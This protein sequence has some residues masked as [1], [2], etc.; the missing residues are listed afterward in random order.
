MEALAILP[1]PKTPE[2]LNAEP[3]KD[4]FNRIK[5][6][7]DELD[8]NEGNILIVTHG[9]ALRMAMY[10]AENNKEF[11][12]GKYEK[13]KLFKMNNGDIFEWDQ[14]SGIKKF[15]ENSNQKG[16]I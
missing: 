2:L 16:E 9:G 10:Y 5:S 3:K 1:A 6:F 13:Y 14:N 4:I 11:D 15:R 8:E 12:S 7:F